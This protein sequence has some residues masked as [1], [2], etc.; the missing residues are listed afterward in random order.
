MHR[1]QTELYHLPRIISKLQGE[2]HV[3]F[4]EAV[5]S[6]PDTCIGIETCEELFTPQ[7]PHI[8]MALD[9]VEVSL[10]NPFFLEE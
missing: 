9:G 3:P 8:E 5:I 1:R 6:T 7:A 10:Y 4:G 2:T